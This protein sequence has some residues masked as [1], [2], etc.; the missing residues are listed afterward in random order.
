MEAQ[1][2]RPLSQY[3]DEK[4][5]WHF[6]IDVTATQTSELL[7]INRNTVNRYYNIFRNCIYQYQKKQVHTYHWGWVQDHFKEDCQL[8]NDLFF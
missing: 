5:L 4:I 2:N 3:N 8:R 1:N 6:I 7:S